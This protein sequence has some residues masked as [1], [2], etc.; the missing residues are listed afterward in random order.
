MNSAAGGRRAGEG[1][2][3]RWIPRWAQGRRGGSPARC[4]ASGSHDES[5]G[6][7]R[8]AGAASCSPAA[9]R[10]CERTLVSHGCVDWVRGGGRGRGGRARECEIGAS[11]PSTLRSAGAAGRAG[12]MALPMGHPR[13]PSPRNR[14]A[15]AGLYTSPRPPGQG[16]WC[17]PAG[18]PTQA[19][20]PLPAH[21][22]RAAASRALRLEREQPRRPAKPAGQQRQAGRAAAAPWAAMTRTH[23]AARQ[24]SRCSKAGCRPL[25]CNTPQLQPLHPQP[26]MFAAAAAVLLAVL[27][28]RRP[29]APPRRPNCMLNEFASHV[30]GVIN[31]RHRGGGGAAEVSSG[32]CWA[33]TDQ[34]DGRRAAGIKQCLRGG[35]HGC[36]QTGYKQVW[37]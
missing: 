19:F 3:G 29:P 31:G 6:A 28:P 24:P 25:S 14:G 37:D 33:G 26:A 9:R 10:T 16:S 4:A 11:A 1:C 15:P 36:T 23:P 22:G 18:L 8:A 12:R 17:P 21:R 34:G 32:C 5:R 30:H 35:K 27:V 13:L 7:G 20:S 2:A